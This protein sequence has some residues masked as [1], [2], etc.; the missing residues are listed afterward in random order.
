MDT[1]S[2]LSLLVELEGS[3][4][5]SRAALKA[6][7]D[8]LPANGG[9]GSLLPI[10]ELFEQV[11]TA[12]FLRTISALSTLNPI[13][14]S[15]LAAL[16]PPV[17]S[18]GG[19]PDSGLLTRIAAAGIKVGILSRLAP[20]DA[21]ALVETAGFKTRGVSFQQLT[22]D[23]CIR[24]CVEQARKTSAA[25][26]ILG[27]SEEA[28]SAA[29]NAG[30]LFYH[31][32]W[33][34]EPTRREKTD[35]VLRSWS[36]LRPLAMRSLS[37]PDEMAR[38]QA[39][40][41]AQASA[42]T[43]VYF[44]G[45]GVSV[46]SKIGGWADHY[47]PLIKALSGELPDEADELPE[48]LQWIASNRF[49][50]QRLFEEFRRSFRQPSIEPNYY[51]YWM[52]RSITGRIWTSNYDELFETAAHRA[53]LAWR[54]ARTDAELLSNLGHPQTV[55]KINGDFESS[56]YRD[57]LR[58]GLVL[59]QEHFDRAEIDRPEIW[60]Q[61]EDD[62]RSRS[63]VFVGV[64]LRDPVLRRVLALA[65]ARIPKPTFAHY[66]IHCQTSDPI[67]RAR[68]TMIKESLWRSQ[69][70]MIP[71]ATFDEVRDIVCDIA[72]ASVRPIVGVTG[73]IVNVDSKEPDLTET[74]AGFQMSLE[75]VESLCRELGKS[76]S[77]VGL[78][79]SSGGSPCIGAAAVAGALDEGGPTAARCYLKAGSRSRSMRP[80]PTVVLNADSYGPVRKRMIEEISI[81]VAMGGRLGKH[82][83]TTDEIDEA[84]AAGVP[85]I[86]IPQLGGRVQGDYQTL[87]QKV[88]KPFHKRAWT[89]TADDLNSA[90]QS[91][92]PVDLVAFVQRGDL[93]KEICKIA[94]EMLSSPE[95]WG[96]EAIRRGVDPWTKLTV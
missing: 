29:R 42:G 34:C 64:S 75:R 7:I 62:Y 79:V 54:V 48:F 72:F 92:T 66:L 96:N 80:I 55:I 81:L 90:I 38:L 74:P 36:E 5:S 21:R 41:E 86:L 9:A 16:L 70:K 60:R 45:A 51:H 50:A 58:W 84:C 73:S 85:V 59:L 88:S 89:R 23:A 17:V 30:A 15:Q 14:A 40:V 8:G 43:V 56:T 46:P 24:G 28:R 61:F 39:E 20:E 2:P 13:L 49:R 71:V 53:G 26:V 76:L 10:I 1:Q 18:D 22:A 3:I 32:G 47:V 68:E 94:K 37:D 95:I 12:A 57:D 33:V 78:R 63:I 27:S 93:A 11:E 69:I 19:R 35:R 44:A 83:G 52:L 87:R 77:R 6:H 82:R 67:R 4:T 91:L 65:R 31:A 25:V